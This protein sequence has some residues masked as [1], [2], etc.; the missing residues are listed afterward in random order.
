MKDIEKD[1]DD[2]SLKV[3]CDIWFFS[4]GEKKSIPRSYAALLEAHSN[5]LTSRYASLDSGVGDGRD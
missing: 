4:V 5:P 2:D 1:K 3:P